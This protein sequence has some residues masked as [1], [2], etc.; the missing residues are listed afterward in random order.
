MNKLMPPINPKGNGHVWIAPATLSDK[1]YASLLSMI[2]ERRL[3]SGAPVV[4][5]QLASLIG[6]SRT[7]L[8]HALQRLEIEG[9]L[10][11]DVNKSYIV[12]KVEL[13]EYLQSLRVRE[14]LEGEAAAL[15]VDR[16]ATEAIETARANLHIVQDQ[17]PYDVISHWR[18]DDE[19]HGLFI[20]N[21]GNA[22]MTGMLQSLRVTTNLFEIEKLAERL[23]PDTKQHERILDSLKAR[24]A[25]AARHA[26]TDHIR[27]LFQFAV[28]S[29]T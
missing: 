13:K 9:L 23:K 3:P 7:P 22:T 19:V 11:K 27:S 28:S 15:S 20:L 8:R 12:R 18:S 10:K 2:R 21:C 5:Q 24:D 26:V 14:L 16:V 17:K 25:K 1:A 6:V 4:E 29:A